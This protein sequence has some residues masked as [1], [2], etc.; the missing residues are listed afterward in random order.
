MWKWS[1]AGE[2]GGGGVLW[3][4]STAGEWGGGGVVWNWS[5]AG[6][7]RGV[8]VWGGGGGGVVWESSIAGGWVE[9]RE[10]RRIEGVENSHTS[11]AP[12]YCWRS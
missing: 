6:G 1:A 11:R 12:N 4:W 10:G 2:W 8:C 5:T 3:K 9:G 7:G